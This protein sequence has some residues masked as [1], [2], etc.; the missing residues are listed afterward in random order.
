MENRKFKKALALALAAAMTTGLAGCAG[1]SSDE[2]G[3][4]SSETKTIYIY[5][6]KV[7]IDEGLKTLTEK[8]TETHPDVEFRIESTSNDYYTGLKTK[9]AGGG[10]PDI[11]SIDGYS[12]II[13]WQTYLADLSGEEWVGD[14]IDAAQE[15]MTTEDGK[16]YAFP[17]AV[18]GSGYM[19]NV[20]LFEQ[21]GITEMPTTPGGLQE[22]VAALEE[23]GVCDYALIE[24][25]N[26][27]YQPANFFLNYA[28]AAQ[29]DPLA[30]IDQ[31]NNGEADLVNNEYFNQFADFLM[32][33]SE[34]CN[35]ETTTDFNT[36][37]SNFATGRAAMTF[38]GNWAQPT[39]D[40]V[41]P[42]LNL[43]LTLVPVFEDAAKNDSIYIS[44]S[45]WGVNKESE[46]YDEVLEFLNW[47]ATDPEGQA[48]ITDTL[49]LI[50]GFTSFEANDE[51]IGTLGR[52]VADYISEGKV[53]GIYSA[54]YPD[55]GLETLGNV[56]CE[57]IAGQ[58]SKEEFLQA[59]EDEWYNL[60][61]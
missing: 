39:M 51:T 52:S 10:A 34:L 43:A 20:D 45:Y 4:D 1:G 30:L 61:Q 32:T 60:A 38:G 11:F 57:Y 17:L 8:Y 31:L 24:N 50:P 53:L 2:G 12:D 37:T 18:E 14:I 3:S 35:N 13:T 9:F 23:A 44:A 15:M 19:Y 6:K 22:M 49:Q 56:V 54:Y 42:D 21:A 41:N 58:M 26:E 7:E 36:Q 59:I 47:L 16:T 55:G 27:Y 40:D 5:Q 28:I 48:G 25:Y 33:E 46:V 29:D